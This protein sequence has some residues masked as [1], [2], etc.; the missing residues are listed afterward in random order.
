MSIHVAT[1]LHHN[2]ISSVTG[3]VFAGDS[4]FTKDAKIPKQMSRAGSEIGGY[5]TKTGRLHS[6]T[7]GQRYPADSY[8]ISDS[9]F[10]R[11]FGLLVAEG[12]RMTKSCHMISALPPND[13]FRDL[14]N[15]GG[16]ERSSLRIAVEP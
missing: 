12:T 2:V 11:F 4:A 3:F 13:P 10:V 16:S 14:R 9:L 15:E 5:L 6:G 7:A 8:T 1:H